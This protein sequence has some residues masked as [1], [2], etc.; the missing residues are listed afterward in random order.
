MKIAEKIFLPE[1]EYTRLSVLN[2]ADSSSVGSRL[3]D[4][5]AI[6]FAATPG[7]AACPVLAL[8]TG[9]VVLSVS[10]RPLLDRSTT[11]ALTAVAAGLGEPPKKLLYA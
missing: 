2:I 4:V 11:G 7:A 9:T 1:P 3:D 6:R 5:L 10:A 8:P